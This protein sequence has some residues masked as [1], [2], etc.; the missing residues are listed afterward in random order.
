[1]YLFQLLALGLPRELAALLA[2]PHIVKAGVAIGRDLQELR[3]LSE[4][5]PRNCVDLGVCAMKGGLQH[6]GLR[7]LAALLLGCRISK[8]AQTT[9]W[10][11]PELPEKALRYAATDAWMSRRI[12]EALKR[13]GCL[14]AEKPSAPAP[15]ASRGAGLWHRARAAVARLVRSARAGRNVAGSR[16]GG[17]VT[18]PAAAG[19]T[20]H[21]RRGRG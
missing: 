5:H 18:G 19:G 15:P 6:H 12:Y 1:V 11:R 4:F 10:A 16:H 20:A 21:A 17:A 14:D 13:H 3:D 8:S 2:D 9:N 7:G